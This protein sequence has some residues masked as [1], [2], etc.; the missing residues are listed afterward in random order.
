MAK[1]L[2]GHT[3]SDPRLVAEVA[4]LRIRVRDLEAEVARLQALADGE[5]DESTGVWDS[6]GWVVSED[7]LVPDPR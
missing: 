7:L 6:D 3:G 1:A 5:Q 4:R 2:Y